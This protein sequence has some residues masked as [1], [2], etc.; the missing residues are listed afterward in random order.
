MAVRALMDNLPFPTK[1]Q[2]PAPWQECY[3]GV[4][5]G[6][7]G[8]REFQ[9][10]WT[11]PPGNRPAACRKTLTRFHPLCCTEV[12]GD[13]AF[14][15]QASICTISR[16]VNPGDW[17]EMDLAQPGFRLLC[18]RHLP[19]PAGVILDALV[20]IVD[21]GES[22]VHRYSV[23]RDGDRLFCVE[24]GSSEARY[25]EWAERILFCLSS[26]HLCHSQGRPFAEPILTSAHDAGVRWSFRHPASWE[27]LPMATD[28]GRCKARLLSRGI[29]E[30]DTHL[31]VEITR[32]TT[33]RAIRRLAEE[34]A[35]QWKRSGIH[36]AG[37]AL[38]SLQPPPS[39]QEA[40]LFNP[41]ATR[42]EQSVECVML[43]FLHA[44]VVVALTLLG[45]SRHESPEWWAINK[46]AFEIV[47]D[48]L[49]IG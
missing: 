5:G 15:I 32:R 31:T 17:L 35:D 29:A 41:S 34:Q 14:R 33:T 45:P 40:V 36:L 23:V 25:A 13:H 10:E 42:N 37:A 19:T 38:I 21:A 39:F 47:R 44:E 22:R 2:L 26:F 27:V 6:V 43:L 20:K 8:P 49:T 18:A 4:R 16:E 12:P 11:V 28:A 48:S 9:F 7:D 30:Q 1:L 24:A 3:E 46:R